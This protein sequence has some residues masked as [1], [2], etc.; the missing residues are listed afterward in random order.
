MIHR[1]MTI[2]GNEKAFVLN[3]RAYTALELWL[4]GLASYGGGGWP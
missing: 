2:G 1:V 4:A 3:G